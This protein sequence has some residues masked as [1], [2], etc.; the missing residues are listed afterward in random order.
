MGKWNYRVM[1]HVEN[2]ADNQ[3]VFYAVHEVH[4][5]DDGRVT[6]WTQE[7]SGSPFGAT[8]EEMSKDLAWIMTA[9]AK[10]VLLFETGAEVEPASMLADDHM[11][12]IADGSIKLGGE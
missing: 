7:A 8:M 4:Y 6:G 12:L 2:R 9:L 3:E 11:A 10:P 5:A 1:R